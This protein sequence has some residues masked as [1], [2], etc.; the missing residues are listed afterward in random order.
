MAEIARLEDYVRTELNVKSIRYATDESSYIELSAKP[1]SPVLGKRLG[2]GFKAAKAAIE[3]LD[4]EAIEKFQTDRSLELDGETY[5]GDDILVFREPIAGTNTV[6]NRFIS[7]DLDC[8]VTPA[9]AR[10]GLA[11][12]VVNRIQRSRRD[13]GLEVVDRIN[14]SW[15]ADGELA[16]AI[17]QH[18]E[19]IMAET[20]AL[21]L[22][23]D[24]TLVQ[25]E[26][27]LRFDVDGEALT[28][29]ISRA[30]Q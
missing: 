13:T 30:E 15:Y 24:P 6:S 18:A 16:K 25:D 26:A 19:H 8:A 17:S 20:L 22:A 14:L 2:K 4:S 28:L 1:N 7:V 3:A 27:S 23:P 29:S 10:E 12:E 9:L 11:R 5:S 21:T